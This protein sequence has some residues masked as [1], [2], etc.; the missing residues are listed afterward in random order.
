MLDDTKV[1]PP[2]YAPKH[3]LSVIIDGTAESI[4]IR[5]QEKEVLLLK[6]QDVRIAKQIL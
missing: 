2:K 4:D 6:L 1:K 3:V 5:F